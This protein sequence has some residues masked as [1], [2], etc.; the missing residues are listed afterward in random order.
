[1]ACWRCQKPGMRAT[2]L[3][4]PL[5]VGHLQVRL[6]SD[7]LLVQWHWPGTARQLSHW[8]KGGLLR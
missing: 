8:V 7:N 4:I 2:R 6:G 5:L 3:R 1:M